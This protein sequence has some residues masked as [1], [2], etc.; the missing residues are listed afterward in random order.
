M[1]LL[2]Q[3]L[4]VFGRHLTHIVNFFFSAE[5]CA[6]SYTCPEYESADAL[7]LYHTDTKKLQNHGKLKAN[8]FYINLMQVTKDGR[9]SIL[10]GQ[11]GGPS[12]NG[13]LPELR[14]RGR[15]N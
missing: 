6:D 1:E 9:I 8:T 7:Y 10:Q 11:K 5:G 2:S 12:G 3:R 4:E 15:N 13:E 14:L